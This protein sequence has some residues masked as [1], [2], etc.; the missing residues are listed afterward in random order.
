MAHKCLLFGCFACNLILGSSFDFVYLLKRKTSRLYCFWLWFWHFYESYKC[1]LYVHRT[2]YNQY[3]VI[4]AMRLWNICVCR[5][6]LY[7]PKQN[8]NKLNLPKGLTLRGSSFQHCC[9]KRLCSN[10]L[11]RQLTAFHANTHTHTRTMYKHSH[12]HTHYWQKFVK[13]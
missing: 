13:S 2:Y 11:I 5:P 10:T 4:A 12:T 8:Q 7:K 1:C 3:A 9:C 6:N